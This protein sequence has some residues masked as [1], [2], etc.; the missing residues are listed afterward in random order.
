VLNQALQSR[1]EILKL[2]R[3]LHCPPE[4]MSYLEGVPPGDI[5]VLR[6]QVTD[7]LFSADD[8]TLRRLAAAS[9]LLPVS[10]VAMMGER[11]F[12][13]VLSA[14]IAGLL[15]PARAVDVAAKLPVPFLAD[16][17]AELDP[18]RATAVI[19]G[20]G[21]EQVAAVT[22]ELAGRGEF[23]TMG[24]GDHRLDPHGGGGERG[25]ARADAAG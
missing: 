12:G 14:R 24:G 6:E 23:V 13:P 11:A 22:R 4:R 3:L 10:L 8:A 16:V 20:I 17:A 19:A 2:A 1:A 25:L 18:R 7:M 15:E 9:R 5:R 21:P